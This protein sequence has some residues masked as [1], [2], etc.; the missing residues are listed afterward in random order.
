MYL[1]TQFPWPVVREFHTAVLF[2]I[3]CSRARW[4]DSFT[5]LESRLLRSTTIS[6]ISSPH[7]SGA[8]LF[9]RDFQTGKCSH[10]KDHYGTIR[11]E[12]KWL[13]HICARC[14]MLS[15]TIAQH[16]TPALLNIFL[17][18]LLVFPSRVY[19]FQGLRLPV[20]S[21]LRLPVW[22]SYLRD[23][24]DYTVCDFLEF[25]WLVG[26]DYSSSFP[27]IFVITRMPLIFRT[28]LI[29]TCYQRL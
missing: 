15:H 17:T 11:N 26:F 4:G 18:Y 21:S 6:S 22:R 2:E 1:V 27:L 24:K 8:V 3:E 12:R 5:H 25:G 9:C 29:V 13:Q 10:T 23:Y 14:W 16:S 28:Q 20:P 7:P 19:N